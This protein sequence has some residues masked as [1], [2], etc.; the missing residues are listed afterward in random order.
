MSAATAIESDVTSAEA[1]RN[2]IL[3]ETAAFFGGH[4]QVEAVFGVR[5]WTAIR[6]VTERRPAATAWPPG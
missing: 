2:Q 5:V 4:Q 6:A 3:G 1:L